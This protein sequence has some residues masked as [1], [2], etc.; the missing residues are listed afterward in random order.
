MHATAKHIHHKEACG[1]ETLGCC[2]QFAR[3]KPSGQ[4]NRPKMQAE[5]HEAELTAINDLRHN[6]H[7]M[8]AVNMSVQATHLG[9]SAI[10]SL[11]RV[12]FPLPTTTE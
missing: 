11:A 8:T 7:D 12:A 5:R 1:Q 9:S 10:S 2:D 4:T 3:K 6:T